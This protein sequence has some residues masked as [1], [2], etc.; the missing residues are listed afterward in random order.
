MK[1]FTRPNCPR[2]KVDSRGQNSRAGK[3]VAA[4]ARQNRREFGSRRSFALLQRTVIDV[5]TKR[6]VAAN[7]QALRRTARPCRA[8]FAVNGACWTA[9]RRQMKRC[10][11]VCGLKGRQKSHESIL[12]ERVA[13]FQHKSWQKT[14]AR[15]RTDMLTWCAGP[16]LLRAN[17][18][19]K[20][21]ARTPWRGAGRLAPCLHPSRNVAAA[22]GALVRFGLCCRSLAGTIG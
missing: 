8:A 20:P 19:R 22:G 16:C 5:W 3:W 1:H 12:S 10:E 18:Y 11:T 2:V 21:F 6:C 4:A 9:L 13:L 15:S 17:C 14:F 7:R